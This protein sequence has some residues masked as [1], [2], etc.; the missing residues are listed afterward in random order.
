M[1]RLVVTGCAGFIGSNL[2]DRLLALGHQVTGIDNFSTGQ[3]RFLE[4]ALAHPNFRL[5]EIDLLDCDTLK[6]A[7]AGGQM[8]FHFAANADVRFGV[9]HPQKDLQ[10]NTIA[11]FNV[12][13]AMRANGIKEIAFSFHRLGLRRSRDYPYAG[14]CPIS[15]SNIIIRR[16]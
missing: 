6:Q 1:G 10:Q 2:V 5:I 13:E 16:F 9:E 11:T 7:F 14:E 3:R 4:G 8:V 15:P 12:L